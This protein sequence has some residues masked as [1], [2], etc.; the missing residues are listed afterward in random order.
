MTMFVLASPKDLTEMWMYLCTWSVIY[1]AGV[2]LLCGIYMAGN[3]FTK[4]YAFVWAPLAGAASGAVLGFA[5]SVIPALLVAGLYDVGNFQMT[6]F[7]GRVWAAALSLMLLYNSLGR[8]Y[9][10]GGKHFNDSELE[11]GSGTP[12]HASTGEKKFGSDT[13]DAF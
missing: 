11:G 1:H 12:R 5:S 10:S 9:Y 13:S 7:H 6:E 2:Y 3:V 8:K 4:W